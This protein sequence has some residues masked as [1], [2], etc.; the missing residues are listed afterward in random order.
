[1]VQLFLSPRLVKKLIIFFFLIVVLTVI[2]Y[3]QNI[4]ALIALLIGSG[5]G[6]LYDLFGKKIYG[7]DFLLASAFASFYIFGTLTQSNDFSSFNI[8][9]I[10]LIFFQVLYFNMIE[11]GLKDA[12]NDYKTGAKTIASRMGVK[13][14]PKIIVPNN[15]KFIAIFLDSIII[16][17]IISPFLFIQ[18]IYEFGYW[19]IPLVF[20]LLVIVNSNYTMF[21]MLYMK[22]FQRD[23]LQKIIGI[24]ELSRFFIYLGL[25][26]LLTKSFLWSVFLILIPILWALI[27]MLI[28]K[29]I[30]H[31]SLPRTSKLL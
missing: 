5:F 4:F 7:S 20:L 12:Y 14:K 3:F 31:Q 25:L 8:I 27:W 1:M 18:T 9:F 30:F 13:T 26:V 28:F 6:I 22:K 16:C 11:G 17:L 21:R 19:F 2:L 29:L 23:V 10:L 15:F 24:Q